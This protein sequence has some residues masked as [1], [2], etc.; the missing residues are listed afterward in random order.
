ML[1]TIGNCI[2]I[3]NTNEAFI[4]R[5][6]ICDEKLVDYN[7]PRFGQWVED[8][9]SGGTVPKK[10]LTPTKTLMTLRCSVREIMYIEYLVH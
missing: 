9:K 1:L 2:L 7:S 8:G 5:I 4:D 6:V 3:H 10:N